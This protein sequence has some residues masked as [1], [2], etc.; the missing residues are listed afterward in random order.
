MT[1]SEPK[2]EEPE[3]PG[4]LLGNA[5]KPIKLSGVQ[6]DGVSAEAG[7][8]GESIKVWTRLAL[9]SDDRF[10]H[11][12]VE[13]LSNAVEHIARPSGHVVNLKNAGYVLLVVHPDTPANFGWMRRLSRCS[14]CRSA[15]WLPEPFC[16]RTTLPM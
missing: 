3:M 4:I 6:L 10:F 2:N 7:R 16:F 15:T 9:T 8:A 11:R 13:G 14:S 5:G 12:V 1:E